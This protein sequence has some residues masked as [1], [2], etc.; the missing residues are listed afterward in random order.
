VP[1]GHPPAFVFRPVPELLFLN[2]KALSSR[3][4]QQG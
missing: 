2:G 3:V 1:Y 4:K